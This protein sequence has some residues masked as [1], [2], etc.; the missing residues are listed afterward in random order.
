MFSPD[1]THRYAD[2]VND[3][4]HSDWFMVCADFEAYRS[5][6][7]DIDTAWAASSDWT[8]R[9][10]HNTANMGWFSSDR[11]IREYA[12]DIWGMI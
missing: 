2:L 4:R 10:I 5:K 6:Q 9:A 3:L 8:M 7:R 12:A 1:D 11:T